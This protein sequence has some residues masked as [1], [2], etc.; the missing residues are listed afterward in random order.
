MQT[1]YNYGLY[2][3]KCQQISINIL[4][5]MKKKLQQL[6]Q[7][8][9]NNKL[10]GFVQEDN[11]TPE[12]PKKHF[13]KCALYLKILKLNLRTQVNTCRI[14]ILKIKYHLIKVKT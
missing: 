8:K 14:T 9:L 10:F 4:K 7:D 5:L 13:Q 2:L 11:E 1:L 12:H 3:R 6:K